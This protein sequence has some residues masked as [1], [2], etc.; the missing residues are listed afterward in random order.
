MARQNRL[1]RSLRRLADDTFTEADRIVITE[2]IFNGILQR[3]DYASGEPA[4]REGSKKIAARDIL[5]SIV[6]VGD[7]AN[8]RVELGDPVF[9]FIRDRLFPKPR[10]VAP[11]FPVSV[12]IGREDA[13]ERVKSLLGISDGKPKSRFVIVRGWPGVGKTTLVG[14]IGRDPDVAKSFPD[15]ILWASLTLK[16]KGLKPDLMSEMANW[17][18]AL[19]TDELLRAPTVDE[20]S[21]KLGFL[22]QDK[23]ML[24][25]LDD[26]WV[27]DHAIPFL[28]AAGDKCVTLITTRES[29]EVAI[30]LN[31]V[32]E[33]IYVLPVLT[34][35]DGLR[36]L[37]TLSPPAVKKYPEEC[38]ELVQALECL[39]L[40]LHVAGRLI[41]TELMMGLNAKKLRQFLKDI[42]DGAAIIE[43]IAPADREEQGVRPTVQALLQKSTDLLDDY[44]RK[45]FAFLGPFVPRPATFNLK[46]LKN[47]WGVEDPL[48]IVRTLVGHGLMESVGHGRYQ[49]H[50]LLVAHA[51]SLLDQLK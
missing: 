47:Q 35:E 21:K 20:A 25:I 9:E 11:P 46:A 6:I 33:A 42:Q 28:K 26:V 40:A 31:P 32:P 19:G 48:P 1:E 38:R 36:L 24:L 43:S 29:T 13:L 5:E 34:E 16:P 37:R 27:A 30:G 10:G 3:V 22:L 39:P 44:T 15:G 8:V 45:C 49:M 2:A 4:P 18:R 23:R 41:N 51:D 7:N 17:G 50:A 12:F 14:V